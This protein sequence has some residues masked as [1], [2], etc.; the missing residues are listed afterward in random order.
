MRPS[1]ASGG[2]DPAKTDAGASVP[3][4]DGREGCRGTEGVPRNKKYGGKTIMKTI[5]TAILAIAITVFTAAAAP[6][7]SAREAETAPEA[8][9]VTGLSQ[10]PDG[11]D[12]CLD[13]SLY[14]LDFPVD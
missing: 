6:A 9:T 13:A 3:E 12:A 5:V 11:Y 14:V 1:R 8:V 7:S 10:V 2:K 4:A